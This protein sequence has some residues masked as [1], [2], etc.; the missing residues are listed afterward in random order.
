[1]EKRAEKRNRWTFWNPPSP[2]RVIS[3]SAFPSEVLPEYCW[4][5]S[6]SWNPFCTT[7]MV[8]ILV[9]AVPKPAQSPYQ[10]FYPPFRAPV[11]LWRHRHPRTR[12]FSS[13]PREIPLLR[14]LKTFKSFRFLLQIPILLQ[15]SICFPI[16]SQRNCRASLEIKC[17]WRW[18][19]ETS[20]HAL[21]WATGWVWVR[22][23]CLLARIRSVR[24]S[25]DTFQRR[26]HRLRPAKQIWFTL[27]C[28]LRGLFFTADGRLFQRIFV[29]GK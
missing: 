18:N 6:L 13:H 24:G 17:W 16:P 8:S 21:F 5:Q 9:S 12:S 22:L 26:L 7:T 10:Q 23:G 20:S 28:E 29:Q 1:V 15:K 11:T 19:P 2:S 25:L 4:L 27:L 14:R 3:D